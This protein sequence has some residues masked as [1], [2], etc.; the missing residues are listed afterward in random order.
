MSEGCAAGKTAFFGGRWSEPCGGLGRNT[1]GSP[2]ADPVPLCDEHFRQVQEA[3]LIAE[4]NITDADFQRRE[5]AR[6]RR[7]RPFNS[8]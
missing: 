6:K 4:P 7:F 1:V 8:N 5:G 3:G 2:G